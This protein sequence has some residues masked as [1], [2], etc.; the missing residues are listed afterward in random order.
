ML[1]A[2]GAR[3]DRHRLE[4]DDESHG[5]GPPRRLRPHRLGRPHRDRHVHG[6]RR[7]DRRRDPHQ[8]HRPRR[9]ADDPPRLPPPRARTPSS[10]APTSSCPAGRSCVVAARRR[11]VQ[12]QDPGRPVARLPGRPDVDRHRPGHPVRRL[13]PHPRVDVR[14]PPDLHRQ[15]RL[16]GRGHRPLR[17]APR[18]RH[19]PRAAARP[20][21]SSRRTSAPGMAMVIAACCAEGETEIGNIRPDRPRLR[22]DR[23]APAGAGRAHRARRH[24]ARRSRDPPAA[25]RHA[26]RAAGR[27]ARAA[28][29]HRRVR[30]AFDE[31][32]YGEVA[33]PALEYEEHAVARPTWATRCPSTGSSTSRATCSCCART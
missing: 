4:R 1:V 31:A 6:P 15:A 10:T 5:P 17:P 24:R 2:M 19:R 9:P 23:R 28:R 27:D 18:D 16:D 8:G 25:L 26:R 20:S 21:A 14:E 7:R 12:E 22:A 29:D 11:R 3:I 13:G 33:T 30:G 32:G